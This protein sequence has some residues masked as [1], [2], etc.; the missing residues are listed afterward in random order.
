MDAALALEP[1]SPSFTFQRGITRI[2]NGDLAGA[3]VDLL[4]SGSRSDSPDGMVGRSTGSSF[5]DTFIAYFLAR[6]G[7]RESAQAMVRRLEQQYGERTAAVGS[8]YVDPFLIAV[9]HAGLEQPDRVFFWL[10]EALARRS[11]YLAQ[12]SIEPFFDAV[13]AD[14]RFE[15]LL[16]RMNHPG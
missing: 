12:I 2:L 16:R 5:T 8:S 4:G 15:G 3:R 1:G 13:R 14:P 11:F 9:V 6:S 7:E 10:E